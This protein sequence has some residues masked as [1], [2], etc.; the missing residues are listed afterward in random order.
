MDVLLTNI[1]GTEV[2]A[3]G[4]D[5][6][7]QLV[8]DWL[9]E[10]KTGRYVCLTDVHCIMQS[11]R[12]PE[13]RRAYDSA[14]ICLPDGMPLTWTG[15]MRG[16]R[17]MSRV[18]GPDLMLEL[19]KISADRG[20]TNFFLGGA[21]GVAEKLRQR[22]VKRFP[23]LRV[24]GTYSPPWRP[25]TAQ[26]REALITQ[27]ERCQPDLIW[28]GLGAPKQ[29]LFMYEYHQVLKCKVLIGVGAAFDFHSGRVRQAPRWMM[30]V[31]FEWLFRLA[32]EPRRLA[33]RYLRNNP[34]FLWHIALQLLGIRRYPSDREG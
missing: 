7:V 16:H 10:P 29:D 28:V 1:L 9:S 30:N 20:Y 34:A 32:V 11:H 8:R 2:A 18:Y 17:D 14:A 21:E 25:L 15:R 13:V 6:A 19:L 5:A 27:V 31:G 23:G 3:V 26:E 12:R 22:M 33:P 24:V 4:P